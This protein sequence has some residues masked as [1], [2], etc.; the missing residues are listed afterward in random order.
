MAVEIRGIDELKLFKIGRLNLKGK[1][2]EWFKN[3]IIAPTDWQTME[4]AMLLKYG[5]IDK[6]E[7]KAKL[8]LIKQEPKQKVHA[9]Y[10]KLEKLFA[11]GKLEDG[12]QRKKFLSQLISDIRKM[13][14]MR[15]YYKSGV[16]FMS[17][18]HYG[19]LKVK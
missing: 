11:R 15:H 7:V 5:T 14:V 9:Y 2:K 13:C 4:V 16:Q 19:T 3:L 17:L 10:D 12:E 8:D 18:N 1:S 6:E